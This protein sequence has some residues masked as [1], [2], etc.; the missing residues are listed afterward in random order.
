M[1]GDTAVIPELFG[2]APVFAA[3]GDPMRL[4]IIAR[5]C[6]DGPLSTVQL[7]E[8]AAISRQGITKH[9]QALERAGLVRSGRLGRERVWELEAKRLAEIR[10]HLEQISSQWDEALARLRMLVETEGQR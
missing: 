5:L 10:R 8:G 6:G 7:R 1:S 4:Q 3:L 2:A 9:L